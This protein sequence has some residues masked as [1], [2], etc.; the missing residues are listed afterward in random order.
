MLIDARSPSTPLN[1]KSTMSGPRVE[2]RLLGST[3]LRRDERNL[4]AFLA[5]SKRF[6]LLTYLA[7][8]RPRG[9]Q[10]RDALLPLF[11]PEHGQKSGRNAL[12]NMLYHIRQELGADAV[13]NRGSEEVAL[14]RDEFFC[15]V[16]A[17]EEALDQGRDEAGLD[18]YRG[19]FLSGFHLPDAAPAFDHWLSRERDRLHRM[20]QGAVANLATT[21]EDR[22]DPTEAALWWR[23]AVEED[24]FDAR[25]V[26][27][28]MEAL[29]AA[30]NRS[31]ALRAGH[32]YAR[33]LK[34]EFGTRPEEAVRAFL[35]D[36][37]ERGWGLFGSRL[38]A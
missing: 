12:S 9:F 24:P 32:T 17:F 35:N 6:G 3:E 28:L 37:R 31:A 16:L 8:A 4:D 19:P 30:G 2:L 27:R 34:N 11:W 10:R 36:L 7:I 15:D 38:T 20:H 26:R 18:L 14:N 21:A 13:V 23:K 25:S 29:V 5:G 1:P 22:G 33:R